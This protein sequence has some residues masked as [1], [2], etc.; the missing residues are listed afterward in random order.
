MV[1][2]LVLTSTPVFDTIEV[3]TG[4]SL[5]QVSIDAQIEIGMCV[6]KR[7]INEILINA[8]WTGIVAM[9]N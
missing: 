6:M 9:D 7:R 4:V 5:N 3:L 1:P 2:K 8:A